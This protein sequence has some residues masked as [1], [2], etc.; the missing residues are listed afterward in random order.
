MYDELVKK[1][2]HCATD[3]MHCLSCG[4]DKDGRCFKR[5]MTQAADAIEERCKQVDKIAEEAARL[6]TKQ[7]RWIPVSDRLPEDLQDVLVIDDGQIAIGHC[8]H[9][10]GDEEVYVE[11][12]DKLYYPI[13]P[14]FWMPLPE[15]P[16]EG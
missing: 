11:W 16:K 8:E 3:P 1:I 14:P 10:Y 15:P 6:Y 9:F 7:P 12:H 4:E 5:L 13:D 2:R